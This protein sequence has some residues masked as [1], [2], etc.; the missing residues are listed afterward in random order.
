MC[1]S[2]LSSLSRL[3]YDA[4]LAAGQ[5]PRFAAGVPPIALVPRLN[6]PNIM[7][8]MNAFIRDLTAH[9]TQILTPRD[10]QVLTDLAVMAEEDTRQG[11]LKDKARRLAAAERPVAFE[12]VVAFHDLL[13]CVY[14]QRVQKRVDTLRKELRACTQP[15]CGREAV[16]RAPYRIH[17]PA[18]DDAA[19]ENFETLYW[20]L[21]RPAW[22][23]ALGCFEEESVVIVHRRYRCALR[24]GVAMRDDNTIIGPCTSLRD[25]RSPELRAA[26][27]RTVRY[28]EWFQNLFNSF[29]EPELFPGDYRCAMRRAARP[30]AAEVV[31]VLTALRNAIT[32]VVND[33]FTP[34]GFTP[35]R[36]GEG[37]G[38]F[39]QH[40]VWIERGA[41]PAG[42]IVL[43]PEELSARA[44]AL[45]HLGADVRYEGRERFLSH[46]DPAAEGPRPRR[47]SPE[48]EFQRLPRQRPAAAAPSE[49]A[50]PRRRSRPPSKAPRTDDPQRPT[51]MHRDAPRRE[52][53]RP[54]R[55][56]HEDERSWRSR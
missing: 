46:G 51:A 15:G 31:I 11:L 29:Y 28:S 27:E 49:L 32:Q 50:R 44:E 19:R 1:R 52:T 5:E 7:E 25:V 2:S 21:Q 9:A 34:L 10:L 12:D 48:A 16:T 40:P 38:W 56:R 23:A 43:P 3:T 13:Q 30:H 26:L 24:I 8:R 14:A 53:V 54:R 37:C 41:I 55:H 6:M 4:I 22:W 17:R 39:P 20:L 35:L 47:V 18:A 42:P 33:L 45:L 36:L